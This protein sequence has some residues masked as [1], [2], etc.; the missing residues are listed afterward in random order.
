MKISRSLALFGL[1]LA[2]LISTTILAHHS[3]ND[4]YDES[5]TIQISGKVV[6]WRLVNP[7]PFLV[8]EVVGADGKAERWDLSF[9]GS[10][11]APLRRQGYTPE[12]FKVGE[13]INA[14]GNPSL[15]STV[16]GVLIR[17]GLTRQDGSRVP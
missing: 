14:R 10:A 15:S 8:I 6:S 5:R 3:T 13:I 9:G 2:V 12:T 4:V 17:G 16:K 11:A 7:H 1:G